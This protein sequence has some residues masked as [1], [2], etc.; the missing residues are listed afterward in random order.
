MLINEYDVKRIYMGRLDHDSDLFDSLQKIAEEKN[1]ATGIIQVIG[2]AKKVSMAF[3]NEPDRK[4][5]P[6]SVEKNVE[7]ASCTGNISQKDGKPM[8]HVHISVSDSE[9]NTYSGHLTPGTVIFAGE[10]TIIENEGPLLNREYDDVTG[11]TLW[12][13][14]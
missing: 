7:I 11:L 2:A 4:Y 13:Y 3:Y 10:F 5:Y 12:R 14:E 6:V 9:G 8:I 1:I